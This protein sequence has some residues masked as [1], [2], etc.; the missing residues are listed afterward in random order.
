MTVLGVAGVTLA[1]IAYT[2]GRLRAGEARLRTLAIVLALTVVEI[3]TWSLQVHWHFDWSREPRFLVG[4]LMLLG[5]AVLIAV[6]AFSSRILQA[7]DRGAK[8][9]SDAGSRQQPYV[10]RAYSQ[11][12]IAIALLGVPI[13]FTLGAKVLFGLGRCYPQAASALSVSLIA[14]VPVS[15]I[16]GIGAICMQQPWSAAK[17]TVISVAYLLVMANVFILIALLATGGRD[18]ICPLPWL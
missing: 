6:V 3:V 11:A 7:L 8:A 9:P 5:P 2:I 12:P 17:R 15:L 1:A 4:V 14:L 13:A 16:A 18:A 10:V